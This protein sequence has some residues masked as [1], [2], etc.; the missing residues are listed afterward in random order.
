GKPI[1]I[2]KSD[3]EDKGTFYRLRCSHFASLDD[4]SNL[5]LTLSSK[6]QPCNVIAIVEEKDDVLE[7][8]ETPKAAEPPPAP[9]KLAASRTAKSIVPAPYYA[10]LSPSA[11]PPAAAPDMFAA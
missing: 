4:A 1:D 2:I 7:A 6:D 5:C 8:T 11:P 9:V 3:V 10:S